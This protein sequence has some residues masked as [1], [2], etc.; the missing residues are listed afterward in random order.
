MSECQCHSLLSM[1][2]HK[3]V[4]RDVGMY[5]IMV[6]TDEGTLCCACDNDDPTQ[7]LGLRIRKF[8]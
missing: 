6:H 7:S 3:W 8:N 1:D 5:D 4:M 2:F